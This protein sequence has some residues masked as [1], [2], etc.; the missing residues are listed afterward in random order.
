MCSL[1]VSATGKAWFE[2]M[3]PFLRAVPK[4]IPQLDILEPKWYCH[5]FQQ[6]VSGLS[7]I[8]QVTI[9]CDVQILHS[10]SHAHHVTKTLYC[11]NVSV[12]EEHQG[13]YRRTRSES[14]QLS[15]VR[16][17]LFFTHVPLNRCFHI[18][19]FHLHRYGSSRHTQVLAQGVLQSLMNEFFD[20]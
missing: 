11:K 16:L 4:D 14:N 3:E 7:T 8:P 13:H 17:A 20:F 12:S 2:G 10:L 6:T 19:T 9:V 18:Y 5:P 1:L 15:L